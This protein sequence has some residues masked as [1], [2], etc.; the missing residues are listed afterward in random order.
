MNHAAP[1]IT[2]A[3]PFYNAQITLAEAVR[4]IQRQSFDDFE[5]LLID[6]GSTDGSLEIAKRIGD[7]RFRVF[8]DGKNLG[9]GRRL[10]Q[11]AE[12]A[13]GHLLARMDADDIMHPCRLE[14]Q[15]AEMLAHPEIDVLG[16]DA[17]AIDPVGNLLGR[18]PSADPSSDPWVVVRHG[19]FIHPTVLGRT[20]W[21]RQNRYSESCIR[22]EDHELWTRCCSNSCF[23]VLHEP[24][25]FYRQRPP[26]RIAP[27]LASARVVDKLILAWGRQLAR[28]PEARRCL[29]KRRLGRFLW[30]IGA[31]SGVRWLRWLW[32]RNTQKRNPIAAQLEEAR[33]YSESLSSLP[34]RGQGTN[35]ATADGLRV[36]SRAA[37]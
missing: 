29:W 22:A 1:L 12:Q 20:N 15:V 27:E 16:T 36:D 19:I 11:G 2:I 6:D 34:A 30:T 35:I 5:V 3:L 28:L 10:N 24:L 26:S 9:L 4:S 17:W 23:R 14:R 13:R 7:T 18:F 8:S 32:K 25:L 31:L 37:R 33:T 21:F